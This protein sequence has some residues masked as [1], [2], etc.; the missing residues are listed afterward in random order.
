MAILLTTVFQFLLSTT[1]VEKSI[2]QAQNV[3]IERERL[4]EK[5]EAIFTTVDHQFFTEKNELHVLFDAGIDPDPLF[6]GQQRAIFYCNEQ[7]DFCCTQKQIKDEKAC[8]TEI[9]LKN[10]GSLKWEFWDNAKLQWTSQW[11]KEKGAHPSLIR[12]RVRGAKEMHEL[13]FILPSS[14]TVAL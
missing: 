8:R 13:A 4:Q 2:E 12:L 14:E 6:S 5:L 3:L 10:V 9:L 7:K 1:K 11:P